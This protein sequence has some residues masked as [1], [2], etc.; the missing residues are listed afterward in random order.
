MGS[1]VFLAVLLLVS[2]D[3]SAQQAPYGGGSPLDTLMHTKLWTDVPDAKDFVRKTRPADQD[4]QYQP[5]YGTDPERPKPKTQAEL[6]SMQK[7]LEQ[8]AAK[9]AK[10][11][12]QK[13]RSTAGA[14]TK[15]RKAKLTPTNE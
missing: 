3:A 14:D 9:N 10:R 6:E 2:R 13:V 1:G 4:L 12:G 7:E 15:T 8:A 11:S 5:T